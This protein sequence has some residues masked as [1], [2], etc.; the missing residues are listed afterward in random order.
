MIA[1]NPQRTAWLTVLTG[2]VLFCVI[3]AGSVYGVQWFIF[4]S[5]ANLVVNASVAQGTMTI[6]SPDNTNQQAILAQTR[7]DNE[8]VVRTDNLSQGYLQ[9]SNPFGERE[10]YATVQLMPGSQIEVARATR[11]RFGFGETPIVIQLD[12]A[13]G[14]FNITISSQIEQE[15]RFELRGHNQRLR[16]DE[17]GYIIVSISE[18]GASV[19]VREGQAVFVADNNSTKLLEAGQQGIYQTDDATMRLSSAINYDIVPHFLYGDINSE[20]PVIWGCGKWVSATTGTNQNLRSHYE[21]SFYDDR[22]TEHFWRVFGDDADGA[23][24]AGSSCSTQTS[25]NVE[26]YES[27]KIRVTMNLTYH[28][29]NGCGQ[30]GSECVLMLR[31]KYRNQAQTETNWYRGF[32]IDYNPAFGDPI[33][34]NSCFQDHIKVNANTWYTFISDEFVVGGDGLQPVEIL[35]LEVYSLGHSFDAYISEFSVVGIDYDAQ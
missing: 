15:I 18:T 13:S 2:F 31:M 17:P 5:S 10:T 14:E 35:E 23:G 3:C 21:Q 33:R 12:G 29:L 26:E 30:A 25:I 32:Y 19:A 8:E 6:S 16:I 7:I 28:S 20:T 4:D 9:F 11:S 22:L 24:P 34:C 1:K 27:L